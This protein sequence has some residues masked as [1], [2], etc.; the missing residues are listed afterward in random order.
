MN[1]TLFTL[2]ECGLSAKER[3][4]IGRSLPAGRDQKVL[5]GVLARMRTAAAH[6]GA[7]DPVDG[8]LP[9]ELRNDA[10]AIVRHLLALELPSG[11][12]NHDEAREKAFERAMDMVKDLAAGRVPIS[13]PAAPEGVPGSLFSPRFSARA[14]RFDAASQEGA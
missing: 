9:P 1:W 7:I 3:E 4:V 2:A 5:D 10:A 11:I 6:S 8:T 13:R 14:Q 12:G